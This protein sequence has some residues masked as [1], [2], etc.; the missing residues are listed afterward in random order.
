MNKKEFMAMSIPYELLMYKEV[1]THLAL[2]HGNYNTIVDNEGR[3]PILHP[4]SD[5][6]KEIEHNGEKFVPIVEL[7]RIAL[8]FANHKEFN[9]INGD[10]GFGVNFESFS[11]NKRTITFQYFK[12]NSIQAYSFDSKGKNTKYTA[13][14][15]VVSI[16]QKLIEYH[17]DIA[18]LIKKGEAIDVNTFPENPYK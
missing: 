10:H 2:R 18:G 4:L 9:I 1:K 14:T 13:I 5:L 6:T 15:D 16:I 7:A 17:F 3:V 12:N 11:E 8:P